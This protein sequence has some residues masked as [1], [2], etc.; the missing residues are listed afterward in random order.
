MAT[1]RYDDLFTTC[2]S[3]PEAWFEEEGPHT[4]FVLENPTAFVIALILDQQMPR[5]RAWKGPL[6]LQNRLG[7]LDVQ[8][9]SEMPLEELTAVI[10]RQPALHR[11]TNQKA[12]QIWQSCRVIVRDYRGTLLTSGAISLTPRLQR[13]AYSASR[14]L[15]QGW[16]LLASQFWL[17]ISG[18]ISPVWRSCC[19][20]NGRTRI[21][22]T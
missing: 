6:E 10:S 8:R 15:A 7:H 16:D 11:L 3:E 22:R 18:S 1:E 13:S 9:I 14:A 4:R 2:S 5:E 19:P 12:D 21:Y 20:T 17:A